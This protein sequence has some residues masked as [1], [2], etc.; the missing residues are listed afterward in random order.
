MTETNHKHTCCTCGGDGM[1]W[2]NETC[3]DCAGT[4]A[5]EVDLKPC[6]FCGGAA[7]IGTASV[8]CSNDECG[9]ECGARIWATPYSAAGIPSAI[10]TW[11]RRKEK[12]KEAK[13]RE[14]VQWFSKEM[15]KELLDNDHKGGWDKCDDGY[16]TWM[17]K[18]NLIKLSELIFQEP[19]DVQKVIKEAT[20]VANYAMMIADNLRSAKGR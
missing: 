13:P 12:E 11:N 2:E 18:S 3:P 16:L 7:E 19:K 15:E 10:E 6:P 1:G 20:D 17:L 14:Q 8:Y 5:I 9:A 4:G